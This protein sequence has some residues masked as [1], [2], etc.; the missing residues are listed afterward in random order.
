MRGVTS[1]LLSTLPQPD[2]VDAVLKATAA[3]FGRSFPLMDKIDVKGDA[4]IP[5][6]LW[7]NTPEVI[8]WNF[9]KFLFDRSGALR[10][11]FKPKVSPL[12]ME[13]EIVALLAEKV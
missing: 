12:Q 7:L 9:H 3:N 5:L 4:A 10:G 8:T 6:F 1:A 2:T 11:S 13:T